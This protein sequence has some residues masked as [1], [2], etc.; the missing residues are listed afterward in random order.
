MNVINSETREKK[1]IFFIDI[2]RKENNNEIFEIKLFLYSIVV[3]EEPH[4]KDNYHSANVINSMD[5]LEINVHVHI[6][7]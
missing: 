7:V 5:I 6:V 1:N 2:K 4:K 3:F